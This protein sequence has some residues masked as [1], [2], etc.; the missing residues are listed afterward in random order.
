MKHTRYRRI[1]AV[2]A[3]LCLLPTL[4]FGM[5]SCGYRESK[6]PTD[7]VCV[8]IR[9]YGKVV[10]ELHEEH[11]SQTVANFKDL[12]AEGF[13]DG[14]VFH[15][16]MEGFMIQGGGFDTNSVQ[17]EADSIVGEFLSNGYLNELAHT[18]GVVSMARSND[19]NSASSQFFICTATA[20]WLDGDYAAFG[21]VVEGMNVVYKI[22]KVA[23][24]VHYDAT[25][26]PHSDWPTADVVID[27]AYFVNP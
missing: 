21:T 11:A 24:G 15:R 20:D 7:F 19:P 6:E 25:G 10:I 2:L 4:L 17:K 23:T 26:Y 18:P 5:T 1:F 12:V 22:E 13:Y 16:V 14:T 8:E 3:L 9:G 27:R